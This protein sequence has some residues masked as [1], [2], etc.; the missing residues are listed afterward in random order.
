MYTYVHNIL[1][2]KL[3]QILKPKQHFEFEEFHE[4]TNFYA[5]KNKR[6][7]LLACMLFYFSIFLK[8]EC[9]IYF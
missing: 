1:R 8:K 3:N 9:K 7:Y 4:Q 2:K 5:F 6:K